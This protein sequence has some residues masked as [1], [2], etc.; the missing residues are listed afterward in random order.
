VLSGDRPA[1]T[2]LLEAPT[3]ELDHVPGGPVA[4]S[5]QLKAGR[6]LAVMTAVLLVVAAVSAFSVYK[7]DPRATAAPSTTEVPAVLGLGKVGAES[8]LRNAELVPRFEMVHGPDGESVGTVIK[9]SPEGGDA[10]AADSTVLVLINIGLDG[11]SMT[12]A[13]RTSRQPVGP[14]IVRTSDTFRPDVDSE[15]RCDSQARQRDAYTGTQRIKGDGPKKNSEKGQEV[16][17]VSVARPYQRI[18]RGGLPQAALAGSGLT[19]KWGLVGNWV[20]SVFGCLLDAKCVRR[21]QSGLTQVSAA[22]AVELLGARTPVSE[23]CLQWW[24]R[25]GARW[26]RWSA[27]D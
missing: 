25:L 11:S 10:A 26:R 19:Q 5:D 3:V 13:G 27:P 24:V 14:L 4:R 9:Q 23:C 21:K 17:E 8:L 12:Y 18:E 6:V 7:S 20:N 1:A 22:A 15:L 2:E 16:Q